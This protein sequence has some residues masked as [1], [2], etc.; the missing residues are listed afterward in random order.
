M[1]ND[2]PI[3]YNDVR[4][5]VDGDFGV[6]A[7]RPFGSWMAADEVDVV[8]EPGAASTE[9]SVPHGLRNANGMPVVPNRFVVTD[10]DAFGRVWRSSRPWNDRMVYFKVTSGDGCTFKVVLYRSE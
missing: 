10:L 2:D 1:K 8:A 5:L 6:F 7:F 4:Q 9:V 3:R